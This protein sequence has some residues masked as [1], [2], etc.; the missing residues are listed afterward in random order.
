MSII[1][2]IS[3]G[4]MGCKDDCTG[5]IIISA[6]YKSIEI[7]SDSIFLVQNGSYQCG[8]I[9]DKNNK[10]IPIEYSEIVHLKPGDFGVKKNGYWGLFSRSEGLVLDCVFDCIGYLG[11]ELFR[12]VYN[13]LSGVVERNGGVVLSCDYDN[14]RLTCNN[15]FFLA[16]KGEQEY[17]FD[18]YG[19]SI[20]INSSEGHE[21]VVLD[22]S[23]NSP[24]IRIINNG[25][26]GLVYRIDETHFIDIIPCQYSS[27]CER[28]STGNTGHSSLPSIS[29]L[30]RYPIKGNWNDDYILTSVKAGELLLYGFIDWD[31]NVVIPFVFED[32]EPFDHNEYTSVKLNGKWGI[33][34]RK[35]QWMALPRWGFIDI[36]YDCCYGVKGL[37][38]VR[39]NG[40]YGVCDVSGEIILP[41]IYESTNRFIIKPF[42]ALGKKAIDEKLKGAFL[43]GEMGEVGLFSIRG[44]VLIEPKYSDIKYAYEG[45]CAVEQNQKWGY[46]DLFNGEIAPCKYSNVEEF[47]SGFGCV[48]SELNL[49]LASNYYVGLNYFNY[50]KSSI[51]DR[52]GMVRYSADKIIRLNNNLFLVE[53]KTSRIIVNS[54]GEEVFPIFDWSFG[55][56]QGITLSI[57]QNR[58]FINTGTSLSVIAIQGDNA[59]DLNKTQLGKIGVPRFYKGVANIVINGKPSLIDLDGNTIEDY[60]FSPGYLRKYLKDGEKLDILN[61]YRIDSHHGYYYT[62]ATSKESA[63]LLYRHSR[64]C[65]N[66]MIC[67]SDVEEQ[68]KGV[69][70]DLNSI[71]LIP[72]Y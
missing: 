51:V 35:G 24:I 72:P 59:L 21:T 44:K 41:C 27:I 45:I 66:G 46:Y 49:N 69:P 14:I 26:S 19:Q 32:A 15:K 53:E 13:G 12:V 47:V 48:H 67:V 30:T 2:F 63:I 43:F 18:I 70:V 52:N 20:P 16:S 31:N 68:T 37:M 38:L 36:N 55:E 8:V 42:L 61:F 22:K 57:T 34:N 23:N 60:R 5:E 3:D 56:D 28:N 33:I 54:S 11:K 7:L 71:I 1:R 40:K 64:Y 58:V 29:L 62:Y 4:Y 25:L 65:Y 6:C 17:C 9:D 10:I 50:E 39:E